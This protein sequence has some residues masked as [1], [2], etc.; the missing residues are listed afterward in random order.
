MQLATVTIILLS[1]ILRE[2]E[3]KGKVQ[4][5]GFVYSAT[6]INNDELGPPRRFLCVKYKLR[7]D[8]FE[9]VYPFVSFS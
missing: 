1:F 6:S 2:R 7:L 8:Q 9:P 5:Q 4:E 3:K